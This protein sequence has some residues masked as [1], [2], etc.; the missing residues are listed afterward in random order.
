L[1]QHC[2]LPLPISPAAFPTGLLN[3]STSSTERLHIRVV[4]EC[5]KIK[6]PAS[7]GSSKVDG[8]NQNTVQPLMVNSELFSQQWVNRLPGINK[9]LILVERTTAPWLTRLQPRH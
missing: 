5:N 4:Q 6:F 1:L 2:S 7:T 8:L 9:S 3:L